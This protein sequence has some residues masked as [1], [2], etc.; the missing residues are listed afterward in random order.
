MFS[1]ARGSLLILSLILNLTPNPPSSSSSAVA[2]DAIKAVCSA[3][4]PGAILGTKQEGLKKRHRHL[5]LQCHPDKNPDRREEA[6]QAMAIL[7]AAYE[8]AKKGKF[9]ERISFGNES[10]DEGG[11]EPVEENFE[12]FSEIHTRTYTRVYTEDEWHEYQEEPEQNHK[13]VHHGG[14]VGKK[15]CGHCGRWNK[16]SAK[17]CGECGTGCSSPAKFCGECGHRHV[18]DAKFCGGCG[19]KRM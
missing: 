15:V 18:G 8:M 2:M 10:D 17:F 14:R 16:P 7:N 6:A 1:R 11:E 5:S 3:K 12:D 9:Y 19:A 13:K 4:T